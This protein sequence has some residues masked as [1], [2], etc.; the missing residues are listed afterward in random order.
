MLGVKLMVYSG[1]PS[2]IRQSKQNTSVCVF[3]STALHHSIHYRMFDETY[4]LYVVYA[5]T[6][7]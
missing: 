7:W 3:L 6:I 1:I 2:L 4:R 5:A